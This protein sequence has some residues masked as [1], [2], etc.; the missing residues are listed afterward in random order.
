MSREASEAEAVSIVSEI[1]HLATLSHPNILSLMGTFCHRWRG[2]TH[3]LL[4]LEFCNE[5]R[6]SDYVARCGVLSEVA[7]VALLSAVAHLH[8]KQLLHRDICP[9][10]VLLARRTELRPLLAN[11]GRGAARAG[12]AAPEALDVRRG[13][14][15]AASDVFSAG[16]TIFFLLTA[17]ERSGEVSATWQPSLTGKRS[18][19]EI[20]ES[21]LQPAMAART[22]WMSS[23]NKDMSSRCVKIILKMNS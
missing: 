20:A 5:G 2:R 11:F 19:D 12:Y 14:V 8:S 1:H 13:A 16:A 6:A 15:S 21:K 10:N 4:A 3:W 17:L 22:V 23:K 7:V 9:Q 18:M